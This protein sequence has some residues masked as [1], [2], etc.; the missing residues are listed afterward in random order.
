MYK[1]T[2]PNGFIQYKQLIEQEYYNKEYIP[3]K[4]IIGI[5]EELKPNKSKE[6]EFKKWKMKMNL[7]NNKMKELFPH[8]F[9]TTNSPLG[10]SINTGILTL[11]KTQGGCFIVKVE[12][13]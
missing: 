5:H 1:I 7:L 11:P 4:T 12:K 10:K 6:D 13:L 2:Y 3:L 9:F 8:A